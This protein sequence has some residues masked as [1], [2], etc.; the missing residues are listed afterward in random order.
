[1]TESVRA[2]AVVDDEE[3]V[4][5]ALSRLLRAS[6]FEVHTY[7]SGAEFLAALAIQWSD[8]TILDLHLPGLSGFDIQRRLQRERA[9]MPCIIITGKDE[10]GNKEKA[11][12]NGA[13]AYLTKP[14]DET[15]LLSTL[16]AAL[17]TDPEEQQAT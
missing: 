9:E 16:A 11:L 6:G 7:A 4:R 12:A 8:C 10:P 13:A 15:I 1:V 14:L 5:K 3:S 17:A 2:I